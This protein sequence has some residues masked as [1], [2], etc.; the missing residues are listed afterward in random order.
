MEWAFRF[1]LKEMGPKDPFQICV[2]GRGKVYKDV[3]DEM[4]WGGRNPQM[5]V[6][7]HIHKERSQT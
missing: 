4:G 2:P 7:H 5:L 1:S 3:G 6:Q